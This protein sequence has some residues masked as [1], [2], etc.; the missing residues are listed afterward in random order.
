MYL[1]DSEAIQ[2]TI[3]Q[4]TFFDDSAAI[5]HTAIGA[6]IGGYGS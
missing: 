3:V 1:I 4:K 5:D 2:D 6:L